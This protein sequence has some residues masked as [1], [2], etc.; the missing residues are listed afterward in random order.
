M[1]YAKLFGRENVI[2]GVDC[3]VGGRCYPDIG[4]AKLR[5]L[6]AGRCAGQQDAVVAELR[7][8]CSGKGR[9]VPALI[10]RIE[11]TIA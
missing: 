2:A 4:W 6:S 8:V 11:G 9:K 5:R 1:R 3:G 7:Q 10:V